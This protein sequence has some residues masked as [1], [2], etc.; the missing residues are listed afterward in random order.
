MSR[1]FLYSFVGIISVQEAN[2]ERVQAMFSTAD[3]PVH[4]LWLAIFMSITSWMMIGTG[5]LYLVMG[6]LCL[7]GLR[8]RMQE[9]E[10]DD[11][12]IY[13]QERAEWKKKERAKPKE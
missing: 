4:V 10:S 1:G 6:M 8:D 3:S 2:N 7:K 13:R 5:L 11:W 9:K 12:R